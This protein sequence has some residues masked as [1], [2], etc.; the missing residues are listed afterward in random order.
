MAEQKERN[1]LRR[2][3]KRVANNVASVPDKLDC[4]ERYEDYSFYLFAEDGRIRQAC[5]WLANNKWFDNFILFLIGVS[6]ITMLV[7]RPLRFFISF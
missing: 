4:R 1:P 5:L 6:S 7:E 2:A 3:T